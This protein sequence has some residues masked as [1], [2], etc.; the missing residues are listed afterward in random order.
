MHYLSRN[1]LKM[2]PTKILFNVGTK[3]SSSYKLFL[4][5]GTLSRPESLPKR[6]NAIQVFRDAME[7]VL[8]QVEEDFNGP[9]KWTVV[10]NQPCL[11]KSNN[12][13]K[14]RRRIRQWM[15]ME[16]RKR[17]TSDSHYTAYGYLAATSSTSQ[18]KK[19]GTV[20]S[21]RWWMHV[22]AAKR[23]DY[24][25][26][27]LRGKMWRKK[28]SDGEI[29]PLADDGAAH[30]GW[31]RDGTGRGSTGLSLTE[32]RRATPCP[33]RRFTVS[34]PLLR[35]TGARAC[36]APRRPRGAAPTALWR[37][38]AVSFACRAPRSSTHRI[39][40]THA[41]TA[42]AGP[43]PRRACAPAPVPQTAPWCPIPRGG[44]ISNGAALLQP[45]RRRTLR[46]CVRACVPAVARPG[47][48]LLAALPH[49]RPALRWGRRRVQAP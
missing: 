15:S 28:I 24:G 7:K 17:K 46:A 44:W 38:H 11:H 25:P 20:F 29:T 42:R 39:P 12:S 32:G 10:I 49:T 34:S 26:H 47:L 3:L 48:P 2:M 35:A 22:D 30:R 1:F 36:L 16:T 45:R 23:V 5:R 41:R 21:N 4:P 18:S 6:L 43:P 27:P 31:S 19:G 37:M 8:P 9:N 14:N 33:G 40:R 13:P